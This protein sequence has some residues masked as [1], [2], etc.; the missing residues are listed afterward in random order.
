MNTN[1]CKFLYLGAAMMLFALA[2]TVFFSSYYSYQHYVDSSINTGRDRVVT[3]LEDDP[4]IYVPGYELIHLI[5]EDQKR[6]EVENL[7]K[8]YYNIEPSPQNSCAM[9]ICGE[10]VSLIDPSK[11]DPCSFY[12][13]SYELDI[14]GNVINAYYNLK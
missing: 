7:T 10:S 13:V 1:I 6:L 14:Y 8:D 9:W 11:V 5:L 12:R 4:C 3:V 2:I